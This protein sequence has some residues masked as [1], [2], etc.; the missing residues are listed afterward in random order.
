MFYTFTATEKEVSYKLE[1]VPFGK[2]N[3]FRLRNSSGDSICI[4]PEAGAT[5]YELVLA[6]RTVIH[7]RD[8]YEDFVRNRSAY[9]GA[10][11]CP[12]P[13]RIEDG[14]YNF[15]GIRYK[16]KPND[17]FKRNAIHGLLADADYS[18]LDT[19][20]GENSGRIRFCFNFEGIAGYPFPF[21][22]EL[23]FILEE[24]S[25]TIETSIENRHNESIPMGDGWHPYFNLGNNID[26]LKLRL[27]S[28]KALVLNEYLIPTGQMVEK[29]LNET[30]GSMSID[31]CFVIDPS[32]G[33][34]HTYLSDSKNTLNI[35][36]DTG[37]PGYNYLVVYTPGD[38]KQIAIEP[39]TSPPN[40]FNSGDGLV[41]MEPDAVIKIRTGITIR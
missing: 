16:L 9:E 4:L 29:Q 38:R 18:M 31:D 5:I 15:N 21:Y 19:F 32:L 33:Q 11:L 24:H 41:V 3:M 1:E 25:I 14:S 13:S 8:T 17:N 39:L 37:K 30:L 20:L 35:W 27:P 6:G 2:L 28:T 22:T 26:G 12:F 40:A 23:N 10:R 36:Q 7:G 34:A